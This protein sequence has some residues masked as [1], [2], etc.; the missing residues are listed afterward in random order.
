MKI[1]YITSRFPYPLEKGDKLRAYNQIKELSKTHEIILYSITENVIQERWDQEI[2]RI[3]YYHEI[4]F[5]KKWQRYANFFRGIFNALP[6]QINYFYNKKRKKQIEKLIVRFQP[7]LVFCQLIRMS[8]YIKDSRIPKVLDY[9]DAFSKG[10]QRRMENQPF[11]IKKLFEVEY[12]RLLS[13]E[14]AIFQ[15]FDAAVIISNAD[16]ELIPV[17]NN[18]EIEIIRNGVNFDYFK[19]QPNVIKEYDI[20]FTGNM[21]Y[22]PNVSAVLFLHNEV[23][24]L[25]KVAHPQIKILIAGA[26]PSAR[27]KELNASNFV[28]TGWV[29][30]INIYYDKSK[31]FIAPM[32][33]G[34]GLQNKLL[35][36][37]AM[38]LP[39]IT[40]P[41]VNKS[42]GAAAQHELLIAET[43][44]EYA[45]FVIQLLG[46]SN[47]ADQVALDGYNFVTQN[48]SWSS[49]TD[50]LN[51]IFQKI[52]Y[53]TS[54]Y[55]PS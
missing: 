45:H 18:N 33:I 51:L 14:G 27:V 34:T 53:N 54:T 39:C 10:V 17:I 21:S 40:S 5:L 42:L 6:F 4:S 36:A 26:N 19:P 25:L 23:L 31:I 52:S 29:E 3:T 1:L 35:E 22:P 41:L 12:R 38:R 50:Q 13:Y 9:M 20:V 44:E 30:D 15:H 28:V 7:D 43:A 16:K 47:F 55:N 24:P 32:F 37:M 46:N 49:T 48:F 8:E 2:N 11:Y